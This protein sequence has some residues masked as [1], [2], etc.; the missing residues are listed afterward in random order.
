MFN[1]INRRPKWS[2]QVNM[3]PN[4]LCIF[5]KPCQS[6]VGLLRP[7]LA[8]C[9]SL[10]SWPFESRRSCSNC[11]TIIAGCHCRPVG[12]F[13]A[14]SPGWHVYIIFYLFFFFSEVTFGCQQQRQ[15]EVLKRTWACEAHFGPLSQALFQMSLGALLS[16][17]IRKITRECLK[18]YFR[19]IPK[20]L[21]WSNENWRV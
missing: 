6:N 9:V 12:H 8:F 11:I 16:Q 18:Q 1:S 17:H 19:G 3:S 7:R 21:W 15:S 14:H 13:M 5:H 20:A 2:I 10:K 4:R